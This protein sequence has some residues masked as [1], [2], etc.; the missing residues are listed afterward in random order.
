MFKKKKQDNNRSTII[1]LSN[2]NN[3]QFN[4]SEIYRQIR[5]SIE[6]SNIS[7][8]V[9]VI[10]ITSTQPSEGKTTTAVNL[11]AVY[12]GFYENVLLVDCDFRKPQI[13]KYF[14]LT[15]KE[16]LSDLLLEY[17]KTKSFSNNYF[18]GVKHSTF[19]NKLT[20]LPTGGKVPNPAD[21]LSSEA[22]SKFI[23]EQKNNFDFIIVDCPPIGAVSDAIP[24]GNI[25]DGTIFV[26]SSM[27]T[28]RK[29][30]R[31]SVERLKQNGCNVLG[32]ILT[33]TEAAHSGHYGYYY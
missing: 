27:N 30:A 1:T 8:N 11:A 12:A 25:V 33:H 14:K 20:V 24:I 10:N 6:Y 2:N 31:S 21:L 5:T 18:K 29:E 3:S 22:F 26:C 9:K 19:K 28:S 13:H 7:K 16:G 23:E 4:Y 17:S 32:T 15:N